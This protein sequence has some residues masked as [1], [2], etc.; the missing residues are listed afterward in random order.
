MNNKSK[1]IICYYQ[2]KGTGKT[3]YELNKTAK[4][5]NDNFDNVVK[6]LIIHSLA[7]LFEAIAIIFIIFK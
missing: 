3:Y 5:I 7:L 1:G 4:Q 6:V 2:A